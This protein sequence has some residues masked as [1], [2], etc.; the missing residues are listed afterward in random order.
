MLVW[1]T[2]KNQKKNHGI[3]NGAGKFEFRIRYV[4]KCLVYG[5][6]RGDDYP[7][8]PACHEA[9]TLVLPEL[10]GMR[11][12]AGGPFHPKGVRAYAKEE[13]R[14]LLGLSA[15]YSF[16]FYQQKGYFLKPLPS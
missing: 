12:V 13:G 9:R 2:K 16:F 6:C 4:Q 5:R 1:I 8:L 14:E 11:A 15:V 3:M 10:R 7:V